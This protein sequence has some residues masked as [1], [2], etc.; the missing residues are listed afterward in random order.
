ME[1]GRSHK[2]GDRLRG[3]EQTRRLHP[4]HAGARLDSPT[5]GGQ[6][7]P[8]P[9]SRL[10]SLRHGHCL[11]SAAVDA[12]AAEFQPGLSLAAAQQF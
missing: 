8:P 9:K 3:E 10:A 6:N 1:T 11:V 2:L 12:A 7:P 5:D 4:H